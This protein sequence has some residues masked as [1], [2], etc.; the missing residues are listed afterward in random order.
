MRKE[1]VQ[2]L[3]PG[4]IFLAIL[5]EGYLS[6]WLCLKVAQPLVPPRYN[7]GLFHFWKKNICVTNLHLSM[8]FDEYMCILFMETFPLQIVVVVITTPHPPHFQ[9][10]LLLHLHPQTAFALSIGQS[11]YLSLCSQFLWC[12]CVLGW[13]WGRGEL[14]VTGWNNRPPLLKKSV[15][16]PGTNCM[17]ALPKRTT[18]YLWKYISFFFTY[19]IWNAVF[20]HL[21][22][23][24]NC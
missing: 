7:L 10:L 18:I 21:K 15:W 23:T 12:V 6:D 2:D 1:R 11:P 20:I 14:Q 13:R 8:S 3:H 9:H 19:S 17:W 16:E 4:F 22:Q 24:T 5:L